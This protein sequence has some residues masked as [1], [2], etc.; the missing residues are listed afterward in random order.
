MGI[1]RNIK[2]IVVH[3]TATPVTATL[4]SIKYYWKTV[5]KWGD[6]PGYH[7]LIERNG[8]VNPLLD[9]SKVSYGAYGHNLESIHLAYIGGID[10]QGNPL[11]NRNVLQ[12]DSM[13]FLIEDLLKRYKLSS[14]CGHRD[15]PGVKKACPC[16]DVKEW[17][18][19]YIPSF[20]HRA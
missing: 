18:K 13:Y 19:K 9:E 4:Q 7:Y 5:R 15:F 1:L 6:T 20:P 10:I 2:N 3:C 8:T 17:F 14:V 11:D 12:M 16:F